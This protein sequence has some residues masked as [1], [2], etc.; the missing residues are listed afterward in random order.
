MGRCA[1]KDN[2]VERSQLHA[3]CK[4]KRKD[5]A[6]GR[7]TKK[8]TQQLF[9]AYHQRDVVRRLIAD[10]QEKRCWANYLI[11]HSAG[12]GKSNSIA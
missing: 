6:T 7:V 12:S 3:M 11:Q 9:R 5:K 10:A 8:E 1:N 4:E 2:V